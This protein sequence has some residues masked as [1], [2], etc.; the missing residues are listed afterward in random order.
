[1]AVFALVSVAAFVPET[2][3]W[4][5]SLTLE[6]DW[7]SIY[8]V[9]IP[10]VGTQCR[11]SGSLHSDRKE[12]LGNEHAESTDDTSWMIDPEIGAQLGVHACIT[13]DQANETCPRVVDLNASYL[14]RNVLAG[15]RLAGDD[16]DPPLEE[17]R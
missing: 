3:A 10:D 5:V 14:R 17:R 11:D 8:C 2:S 16:L 12:L 7:R 1:V 15:S 13:Q 4:E 6:E 9:N